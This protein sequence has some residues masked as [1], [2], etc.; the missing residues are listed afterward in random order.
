MKNVSGEGGAAKRR[1]P[2][3]HMASRMRR[4]EW[5]PPLLV[6]AVA[7]GQMEEEVELRPLNCRGVNACHNHYKCPKNAN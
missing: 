6:V 4:S 7:G 5:F 3:G 2:S 1:E